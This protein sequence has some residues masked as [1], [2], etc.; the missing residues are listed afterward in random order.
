MSEIKRLIDNLLEPPK[1]FTPI[2]FWFLNDTLDKEELKRQLT[3]FC[4]KGVHGVVV[5]PRIGLPKSM[6][7]LSEE[8][9]DFMR[10]IAQTAKELDMRLVL[11]DEAMYPSGSAHGEV[12]RRNP[13]FASK[14]I[15]LRRDAGLGEVIATLPGGMRLVNTFSGGTIRGIHFGEDD[16]EANPPPSAD[17]LNK[18][19]VA[20]FIQLTHDRYY[21]ELSP[22]FGS[23]VI[24]FFT[25]EPCVLGRNT[26]GFFPWTDGLERDII[27]EGGALPDLAALFEGKAN[28]TTVIYH[29]ILQK[30]LCETYYRALF[31]WC[32]S[33]HIALMGHPESSDDMEEQAYFHVPGQDLVFRRVS[34]ETGALHGL[35][36]V[37]AKCSADAARLLGRRRNSN[38]CFGVCARKDH[39]WHL[40][41]GDM[42]WFID[43]LAVRGVN[44][45]IPHAFYY[46]LRG[47]RKDER[48]PDVGPNNIWWPHYRHFSTYMKRLSYLL[49]DSQDCASVAVICESGAMPVEEVVPFYEH[50]IGF[51][52]VP[53]EW[54]D[55]ARGYRYY[56]ADAELPLDARRITS[57]EAVLERDFVADAFM[58][59]LRVA[60]LIKAGVPMYLLCNEGEKPISGHARVREKG[61]YLLFDLWTGEYFAQEGE[62]AFALAPRQSLLVLVD[63]ERSISCRP[64]T[65]RRYI[66]PAFACVM[67]DNLQC[68]YEAIY[69]ADA[70]W[71]T[72]ALRVQGEEMVECVVNGSFAGVSFWNEH[73]FD[74]GQYL[75]PGENHIRLVATG[76]AA[77]RYPDS[78]AR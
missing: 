31:D 50:Q 7:Y 54:L 16:G 10:F 3:D 64:Q 27:A 29:R 26:S 45:F 25:D 14:G 66:A 67:Q 52:Y 8:Y 17:I 46:S 2:P 59:D 40:T 4:D 78:K 53:H 20:L 38:E 70:V 63:T 30:R 74:V 28:K 62:L 77:N 73:L 68:A 51:H 39:P 49:T 76:S 48:P 23:T 58:K 34:P 21:A 35:D 56:L 13:G 72:E 11:Y 65:Q 42:K 22:Y 12:V 37:Q 47:A 55:R 60:H 69:S 75:H 71:G 57:H 44:L 18:N 32:D 19:A 33:H 61:G 1:E 41:G 24:G 5:H 6:P 36:S 9:F 15:A 43:Y